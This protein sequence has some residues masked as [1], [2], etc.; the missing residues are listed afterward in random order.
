MNE[1]LNEWYRIR[2][3]YGYKQLPPDTFPKSS[4]HGNK[5][6][7]NKRIWVPQDHGRDPAL[8]LELETIPRYNRSVIQS[9]DQQFTHRLGRLGRACNA[10]WLW[11]SL[12]TAWEIPSWPEGKHYPSPPTLPWSLQSCSSLLHHHR[13]PITWDFG[14]FPI[15]VLNSVFPTPNE[16]L[17][18]LD[19][20]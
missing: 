13:R 20:T 19:R 17:K 5:S 4:S 8:K 16:N 11:A 18:T 6:R 12:I 7:N 3:Y 15:S 1:Q 9:H 14:W 2:H 10:A